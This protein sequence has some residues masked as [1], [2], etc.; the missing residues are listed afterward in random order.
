MDLYLSLVGF[1]V[2]MILTLNFQFVCDIES[3]FFYSPY[4]DLK[5][6]KRLACFTNADF[7]FLVFITINRRA[8]EQ[9]AEKKKLFFYSEEK[10]MEYC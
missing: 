1:Y 6:H 9:T 8:A 5:L 2:T 3:K 10:I 4:F 7:Y